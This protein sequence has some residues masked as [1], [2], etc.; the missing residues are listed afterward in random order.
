MSSVLLSLSL[1]MFV[2]AQALT[3]LIYDC[4]ELSSTD[5]LSGGAEICSCR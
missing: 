3:S 1:S 5:N 2:V 4:I